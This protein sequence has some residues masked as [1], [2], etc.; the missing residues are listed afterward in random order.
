MK[1]KAEKFRNKKSDQQC[2]TEKKKI[3]VR[4]KICLKFWQPCTT[5]TAV[6]DIQIL[7]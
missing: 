1:L 6:K 5:Y 4:T 7:C 3:K 2:I